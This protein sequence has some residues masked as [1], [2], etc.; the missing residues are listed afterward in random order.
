MPRFSIVIPTLR[1]ADTLEHALSTVLAQPATDVEIVVQ[2]N[3]ADPA[4]RAV[5]ERSGDQRIRLFESD[6]VVPMA[7]NWELAL[8]HATGEFI[9]FVGDDDGLLPDACLVAAAILDAEDAEILS[10]EPFL[11]LWPEFWDTNRRNTLQA[12]VSD[13]FN[14][15]S[16]ASRP[17]LERVYGFR[18]HYSKLP[19]LYNSFVGR[20]VIDRVRDTHGRY[21]LG[22]LPDV[23]SG[24]VN[25]ASCETF[26]RSTRPL[27]IAGLS[28]HSMG[29][30]VSRADTRL[31]QGD[32][33]RDFP[34]LAEDDELRSTNLELLIAAEMALLSDKILHG[35]QAVAFDNRG[36][37]RAMADAIN[38]SPSRYAETKSLILALMK[39][40]GIALDEVVIPARL[41]HPPTPAAGVHVL[42]PHDVLHVIDGDS[43]GLRSIEDA[44]RLAAQL[45]PSADAW[46]RSDDA[47][48]GE[49]I[50]PA[51]SA[52]PTRFARGEAGVNGLISGWGEP[53]SW[54]AWSV[55]R[56]CVLQFRLPVD[57]GRPVRV[58]VA[59]RIV[60]LPEAEPRLV[61][62]AIGNQPPQRWELFDGDWQGELLI[63]VP[64]SP[65][66]D[67][68]V[69]LRF[70]NLNAQ[71][72]KDSGLGADT[73]QLGIGVEQIRLL[74]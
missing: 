23:S 7:E 71:S 37:V 27:S 1:R 43:V 2:N 22:S 53:E 69:E 61:E 31:S 35:E 72:P 49:N 39:R 10:W 45:V 5:V 63:D 55:Q 11:Y 12:T 20:S 68:P 57:G 15:R 70:V 50:V 16:I 46:T 58:A 21:F 38:E 44:V 6:E 4:T 14:V 29:G 67:L 25:A 18:A 73:R 36:L 65:M 51:L 30:K 42:G 32:I 48:S 74:E 54:G 8:S 3:G 41:E 19:M 52:T 24:I 17:L 59:Y 56:E 47:E 60:P 34:E 28:Q 33:E 40:H 64:A 26:L 66:Q 9:T 13:E 62:S